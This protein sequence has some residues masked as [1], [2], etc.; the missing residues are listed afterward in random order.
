MTG[1]DPNGDHRYEGCVRALQTAF[2]QTQ[3]HSPQAVS[4]VEERLRGKLA[5]DAI[6]LT[7]EVLRALAYAIVN[8]RG[9]DA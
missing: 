2:Q 1:T 5:D 9:D 6:V 8:D 7:P 4:A 3:L